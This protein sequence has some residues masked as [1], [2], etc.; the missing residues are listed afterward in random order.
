MVGFQL[1]VQDKAEL[2]VPAGLKHPGPEG[3]MSRAPGEKTNK[4]IWCCI[5]F[6]FLNESP[7]M[8]VFFSFFDVLELWGVPGPHKC[9]ERGETSLSL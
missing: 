1:L 5:V 3:S 6:V 8:K 4:E 7:A 2:R 9:C